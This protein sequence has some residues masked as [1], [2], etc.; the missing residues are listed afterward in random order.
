MSREQYED[1]RSDTIDHAVG[2]ALAD[3]LSQHGGGFVTGWALAV[4]FVDNDGDRGWVVAQD[5]AQTPAHT[6]GLLRFHTL[7]VEGD[8]ADYLK[9]D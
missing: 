9:D 8:V 7:S 1:G 4:E 5:E 2:T 3:W 6:L